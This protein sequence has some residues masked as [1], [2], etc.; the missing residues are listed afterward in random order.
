MSLPP[1]IEVEDLI[2][3]FTKKGVLIFDVSN[4]QNARTNYEKEHL[5][6][7]FFVD[8]NTQLANIKNDLSIGG[9]HPLPDH[10]AFAET[11]T[12]LGITKDSHVILYDDKN[13]S[14]AAA[15]FW[16]MLKSA[17]HQKVQVLNGGLNQAREKHFPLSSKAEVPQRAHE[18]YPTDQ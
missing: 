16:W 10:K 9:R 7:A 2:K 17:G 6:G 15:R 11:L 3:I 18:L 14:N 1:I 13:G 4:G 12:A 5:A 8:T